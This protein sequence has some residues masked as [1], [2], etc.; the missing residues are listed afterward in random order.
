MR[1]LWQSQAKVL[2]TTQRRGRTSKPRRAISLC[3]SIFSPSLAHSSAQIRA[4]FSD[5]GFGV[6]CT[7]STLRPSTF[8]AH[9]LPRHLGNLHPATDEKDLGGEPARI[10]GAT[11]ARLG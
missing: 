8:S 4:I 11:L 1:R 2:S 3:Q 5:V 10:L 7:T 6:R 9:S